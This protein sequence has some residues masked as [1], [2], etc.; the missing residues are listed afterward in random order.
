VDEWKKILLSSLGG[1][2]TGVIAQPIVFY[3]TV[4]LQRAALKAN[5]YNQLGR[6]RY[7]LIRYQSLKSDSTV[8][9]KQ[10]GIL[11]DPN[12]YLEQVSADFFDDIVQTQRSI[13]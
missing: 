7:A 13:L 6:I 11:N 4:F 12:W 1:F 9:N 3:I 8:E 2:A 5:L 10:A